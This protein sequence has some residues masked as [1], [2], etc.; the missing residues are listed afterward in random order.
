MNALIKFLPLLFNKQTL[1]KNKKWV[2][3]ATTLLSAYQL[4]SPNGVG[5][6]WGIPSYDTFYQEPRDVLVTRV[7]AARDVQKETAEEFKTALER[8]KAVTQFQGGDL[9]KKFNQ[10]NSA[11]EDS[12]SAAKNVSNRINRVT[13]A[14]NALLE[15]WRTELNDYHDAAIKA[16]ANQQFDETRRHAELMIAAMRKAEQKTKPVL[17]AFRDQVLFVKH[18]LN[19]QAISSLNE[20]SSII[21]RDVAQLII[22]MEASIAEAEAFIGTIKSW[23]FV[24]GTVV[25]TNDS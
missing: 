17:D 9:E 6:N 23:C 24:C 10:L 25:L 2:V 18:N 14:T 12:E 19:M 15:E 11:F 5:A 3:I 16:R 8:F 20:E 21:E 7:E 1:A 4:L 13:D 22:E